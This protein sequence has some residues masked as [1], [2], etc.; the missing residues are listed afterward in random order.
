MAKREAISK[1]VRFEVFKRDCFR[2][3]YCGNAAPDVLLVIDHIVPVAG[4]GDSDILN[5]VTSCD[6]CNSGKS[7]KLLSDSSVMDKRRSQLELL[8]ERREQLDLMFQW[9]QGL[10]SI[11]DDVSGKL[12][13]CWRDHSGFSLT[14]SGESSIR[15]LV[16]RFSV[17][18]ILSAMQVSADAYLEFSGNSATQESCE[19]AFSKIGGIC[20]LTRVEKEDPDL[21]GIYRV[22]AILR[23]RDCVREYEIVPLLRRALCCDASVEWLRHQAATARS[24]ASF[25]NSVT[26][27]C[28]DDEGGEQ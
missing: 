11:A 20:H 13:D 2:C 28:D 26:D 9:H 5:L 19:H 7:D 18:E 21:S 4:G 27:F 12:A 17:D 14:K 24:W 10:S 25:R 16:K 22:R 6:S 23:K 1:R 3:Q 8:Q 15:K